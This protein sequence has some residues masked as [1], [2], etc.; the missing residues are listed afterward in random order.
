MELFHMLLW[1]YSY[2]GR[3]RIWTRDNMGVDLATYRAQIG[4]FIS[5]RNVSCDNEKRI[6]TTLRE[7]WRVR[8]VSKALSTTNLK[9]TR[10]EVSSSS[11]TYGRIE[12]GTLLRKSPQ[13][14]CPHYASDTHIE[15]IVCLL[16]K[17]RVGD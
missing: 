14:R 3:G 17:R 7:R 10:I 8:N 1:S 13:V 15:Q 4:C 5:R 16:Y 9:S 2:Y 12:F 6:I 11:H